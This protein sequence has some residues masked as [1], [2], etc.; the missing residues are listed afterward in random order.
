MA[1][2]IESR[3]PFL[4]HQLVEFAAA[5]PPRLEAARASRPSGSCARRCATSCR[6]AILTRPKMGFPVPF[7]VWMRGGW[8]DV[9]RDVLLDRAHARARH[10]RSAPRSSGCSRRTPRRR[11][12]AP[13]RSGA[14]STSSSGT[15]RSSTARRPDAARREGRATAARRAAG[16]RFGERRMTHPLAERRPA[17]AARQ[18]RQAAHLAPDA[19]PRARAT[20]SPTCRSPTRRRPRQHRAGMREVVPRAR[21]RAAHATRPKGTLR[22]Y[23][24]AARTS[25]TRCPTRWRKYRSRGVSPRACGELLRRGRFDAVVCDFL[26]PAVNLPRALP[27]PSILFTH[28][29]EA[30]IWRR[31]A[32]NGDQ[33]GRARAAR[34]SSGG[35]CCASSATRSRASICVLAVSEADG[36]TFERLYPGA[37]RGAGARRP[38]R[39][40]HGV[41]HA[42]IRRRRRSARTSSSPARW[43]GCRTKTGCSTSAARSCRASAQAEPGRDAEHRRP[44]ADAGGAAARRAARH[45]G[46]RPRRRRAAA[47]RGRQR[48]TSCRCAS[49]AARG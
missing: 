5:L 49:A 37:L 8:N 13:T 39:R 27:C 38:D 2:S 42:P 24:D 14:C 19:A 32:E 26:L 41:L 22:F 10:H 34:R 29:V 6:A 12:R 46:H 31:H 23:A 18:G 36:E 9:A 33:P 30:E 20:R 3:V 35:G 11:T 43:T 4:D 44:R 17:A 25:S 16:R 7:G 15:A 45:R 28:N 48:S 40:R 1:A 47:H 21:D